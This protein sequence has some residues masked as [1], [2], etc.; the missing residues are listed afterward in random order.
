MNF[1]MD[2]SIF[3]ITIPFKTGN[4]ELKTAALDVLLIYIH[5][6]NMLIHTYPFR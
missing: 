4:S 1:S 6:L 3:S 2:F 5:F